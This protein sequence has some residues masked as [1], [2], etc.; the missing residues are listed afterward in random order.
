MITTLSSGN[1]MS[2]ERCFSNTVHLFHEKALI[3]YEMLSWARKIITRPTV[4]VKKK[5]KCEHPC[6]VLQPQVHLYS[7]HVYVCVYR[8]GSA[9]CLVM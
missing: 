7:M 8:G 6:L 5:E 9:C 4:T 2:S 1:V 3:K